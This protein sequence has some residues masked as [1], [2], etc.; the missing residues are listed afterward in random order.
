MLFEH[1]YRYIQHHQIPM[2]ENQWEQLSQHFSK[3]E[4]KKGDVLVRSGDAPKFMLV[5]MSGLTRTY[6]TDINGKEVTRAFRGPMDVT[7]PFTEY[8]MKIPN[9]IVV[10]AMSEGEC[11]VVPFQLFETLDEQ[12]ILK[13]RLHFT[14]K[15]YIQKEN[16]EYEFLK[17]S[18]KE[19]YQKFIQDHK[20]FLSII[21]QYLIASYIGVTPVALSRLINKEE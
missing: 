17:M 18:A 12:S 14:E 20:E 16:R 11:C 4:M 13:M 10:E 2:S 8:I 15:F 6:Y 21:P 7:G 3:L 1:F 5:V 9:R 19:R